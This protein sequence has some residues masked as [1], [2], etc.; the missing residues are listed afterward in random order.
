VYLKHLSIVPVKCKDLQKVDNVKYLGLHMDSH[1][2]W[3]IHIHYVIS[4]I[5]K[6][7]CIIGNIRDLFDIQNLRVKSLNN[8]L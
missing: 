4:I 6:Y 3:K 5:I 2:K 8:Q 1:L 7:F